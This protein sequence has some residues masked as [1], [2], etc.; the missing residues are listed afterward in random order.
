MFAIIILDLSERSFGVELFWGELQ[1]PTAKTRHIKNHCFIGQ[2]WQKR[3]YHQ[4]FARKL[5]TRSRSHNGT[6]FHAL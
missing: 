4:S 3:R 1:A 5:L 6:A 2:R